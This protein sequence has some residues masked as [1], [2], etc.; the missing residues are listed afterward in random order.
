MRVL[1]KLIFRQIEK[2][3]APSDVAGSGA[4]V[5]GVGA[6]QAEPLQCNDCWFSGP[7][8]LILGDG[9]LP[10]SETQNKTT[11]F[12]KIP[13][14]RSIVQDVTGGFL[15]ITCKRMF[16]GLHTMRSG[17]IAKVFLNDH[18][19]DIIGLKDQPDGYSDYFLRMPLPPSLSAALD[20]KLSSC[21]TIYAWSIDQKQLNTNRLQIVRAEIDSKVSWDID[22]VALILRVKRRK[23]KG[24]VLSGLLLIAGAAITALIQM[25]FDAFHK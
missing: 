9:H 16:G 6:T 7:Q 24:W 21:T 4:K 12:W 19:Q 18:P 23:V 5:Q 13:V 3:L 2:M 10:T 25:L 8:T 15:V 22:Y 14:D 11:A 1:D 20:S 17:A